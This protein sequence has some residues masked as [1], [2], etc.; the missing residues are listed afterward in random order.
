MIA[1]IVVASPFAS[2][3]LCS[4]TFLLPPRPLFV[5][6]VGVSQRSS[7]AGA[8][9]VRRLGSVVVVEFYLFNCLDHASSPIGSSSCVA[10]SP[11]P[12]PSLPFSSFSHLGM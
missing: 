2:K 9:A 4:Y 3:L 1:C 12:Q 8:F 5:S 7:G 6:F 10:S 11:R